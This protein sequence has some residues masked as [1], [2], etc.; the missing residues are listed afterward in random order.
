MYRKKNILNY[1][2]IYIIDICNFIKKKPHLNYLDNQ[3]NVFLKKNILKKNKDNQKKEENENNEKNNEIYKL[4]LDPN[5]TKTNFNKNILYA[6]LWK[7]ILELDNSIKDKYK[8]ISEKIKNHDDYLNIVIKINNTFIDLYVDGSYREAEKK[9]SYGIIVVEKEKIIYKKCDV[10]NEPKDYSLK[11]ISGELCA[12]IEGIRHIKWK[13]FKRI[14]LHYDFEGIADLV[15]LPKCKPHN[16][17]TKRYQEFMKKN[18]NTEIEI[19]FIKV[20]SHSGNKYNDEV[21]NLCNTAFY[22]KNIKNK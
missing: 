4:I 3:I 18:I 13:K 20:K 12:V 8:R 1:Y 17:T 7:I 6:Y 15:L 21:H 19:V 5:Y 9:Y 2:N 11:H 22:R 14:K 16:E 10:K